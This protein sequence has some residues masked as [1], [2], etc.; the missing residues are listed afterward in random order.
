MNEW[1]SYQLQDFI[2]FTADA[3]LRLLE[4]TGET[5]WPLHLLGVVLGG[6][7]LFLA[8]THRSRAACALIA[9][10][11]VFVGMAFFAQRYSELNWAGHWIGRAFIAEAVILALIAIT[12]FGT[13]KG[14][15]LKSPSALAGILL[16]ACGLILYPLIAPLTGAPWVQAETFGIHPDPTAVTTLG[17]ILLTLRGAAMWFAAI[18]PA[19]WATISGLTLQVLDLPWVNALFLAVAAALAGLVWKSTIERHRCAST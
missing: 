19:L 5:F 1:A 7:A 3:Y 4:R 6:A 12:S 9:P 14:S 8:L 11:W 13:E 17:L 18:V 10:L 15:N 16:T 2:P